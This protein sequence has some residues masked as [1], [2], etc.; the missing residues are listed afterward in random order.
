MTKDRQAAV[1]MDAEALR[2]LKGDR[3]TAVIAE[4][5]NTRW[6]VKVFRSAWIPAPPPESDP[7]MVRATGTL[8]TA[9]R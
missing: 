6:S 5:P 3:L 4:V 8:M 9:S 7:A 1:I 2:R